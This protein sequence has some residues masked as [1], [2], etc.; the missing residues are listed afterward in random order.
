MASI[1]DWSRLRDTPLTEAEIAIIATEHR[2][3]G[4][5]VAGGY[6]GLIPLDID[7]EDREILA[8]INA[9]LPEAI[10]AKS[11]RR[12]ATVFFRDPSGLIKA[13]KLRGRHGG[14]LLEVLTT[15]QTVIPPTLHSETGRPYV[16]MSECTLFDVSID[17]LPELPPRFDERLEEALKAWL[18]PPT[19]YK[20]QKANDVAPPPCERRMRAYAE[21]A[22]EGERLELAGMPPKSGRNQRLFDASCRLGKFVHHGI[23]ALHEL[24]TALL[25]GACTSNGLIRE[26]GTKACSATLASGLRKAQGDELPLLE[27]RAPS[28]EHPQRSKRIFELM[29]QGFTDD[30][31][32]AEVGGD[33]IVG[34]I[35]RARSRWDGEARRMRAHAK[36][37]ERQ[38]SHTN[39]PT[40]GAALLDQVYKFLGRFVSYP[41]EHARVAHT[42]W[43][44]HA[45]AMD[46]WESTPRLAFLSPEPGSGKTRALEVT[47]PLVPRPVEAVNVSPAYLFRKVGSEDGRPTILFDEIDTV[48]GPKAKD[49]EEIRGPQGGGCGP[50]RRS[51]QAGEDGDPRLLCSSAGGSR[52]STGH[53]SYAVGRPPNAPSGA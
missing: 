8:A 2:N 49:N 3:A 34:E 1:G 23:L 30:E 19:E 32:R 37:A 22:L 9:A 43:N 35:T 21:A 15:G 16:W 50:V 48:F 17:E 38:E 46:A 5:G 45:H 52:Q 14:M 6:R 18:P 53:H 7:T 44:A 10:V 27:D 39:A 26:D 33:H 12:G 28:D 36:T 42:L 4:L 24:E 40:D 29:D 41:S 11:G 20:R 31:V 47:E 13:R 25:G 51:R